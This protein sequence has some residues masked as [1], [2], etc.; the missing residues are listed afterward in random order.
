MKSLNFYYDIWNT[1]VVF[2]DRYS[3]TA[4]TKSLCWPWN[5]RCIDERVDFHIGLISSLGIFKIIQWKAIIIE[6]K[7]LPFGT[8]CRR[9]RD[10]MVVGFTSTCAISAYH[11]QS[12]Q[13]E[14]RSWQGVLDTVCDQ[15]CQ[16][17]ATGRWFSPDTPVS[18]TN[19][20]DLH[21]IAE[22]LLNVV[23]N[24]INQTK[25]NNEKNTFPSEQL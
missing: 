11:H 12:W 10:R 23:L 8:R 2:F 18:S 24:T 13:F 25:Q 3:V 4:I 14:P 20:T 17:R 22:I 16:W 6:K 15:V 5:F 9:G 7:H 1:H 19:K 21:D